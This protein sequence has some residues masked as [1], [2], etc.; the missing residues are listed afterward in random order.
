MDLGPLGTQVAE[1]GL[2]ADRLLRPAGRLT[3]GDRFDQLV[4]RAVQDVA[5]RHED[6]QTQPLGALDD[7][8]VDLAGGQPDAAARQRLDQ[9]GG[10]EHP[11]L[12]HD[13]AQVPAVVELCGH[14]GS[15]SSGAG[16]SNAG[17][18]AFFNIVFM[19]SSLTC[20]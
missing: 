3:G 18:S 20:V 8:P 11:P 12:G 5:Q 7:Q 15:L 19:K 16:G 6:L 13:R 17:D 2:A 9:I 1:T 10:G 14:Q 4:H